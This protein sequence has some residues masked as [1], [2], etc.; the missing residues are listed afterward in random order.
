VSLT[1]EFEDARLAR[2]MQEPNVYMGWL[3]PWR[4]DNVGFEV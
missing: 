2:P 4:P 1:D 3:K